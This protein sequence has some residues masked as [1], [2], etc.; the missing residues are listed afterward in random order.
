MND[1]TELWLEL[2]EK[3]LKAARV[4]ASDDFLANVVLFHAQQCVQK[5]LK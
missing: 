4:L 1:A 2:A 3:D 5:V